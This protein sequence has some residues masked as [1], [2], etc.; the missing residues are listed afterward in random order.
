METLTLTRPD[1]WHLHLRDG[2]ILKAVLPDTAR[3]FARAIV[4]PNL[5]PPVTT[6][7]QAAAYRERILAAVPTGMAF[8]PLMTLYL[9]DNTPPAEIDA[10]R[11]CGFVHGVKLYPAGATTNSDA[12]VTDLLKCA[13]TL[14]R[15]EALGL[16]LLIHGEVTDPAVDVFDREAVFI[17]TVLSPLLK[18]FPALKVVL[19]HITTREGV[20]FVAT[21]GR[22][23][24]ATITAHHLL[25]NRNAIFVGGIRPH[26]YCLPIL[27]RETHRQALVAAAVSGNPK[28]FLGTDSAPHARSTK[29]AACGCAGCYTAHAG[30]ELYAEAFEAAGALDRLE[31]FASFHG[32]DFYGLPRNAERITLARWSWPVPASQ[33]MLAEDPLVPLRAGEAVAWRLDLTE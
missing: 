32:P 10:A 27:K 8:E 20:Q 23:V 25:L 7:A 12:G 30:I 11:D 9:T 5:K 14:A 22:N 18:D 15:M 26:H 17:D 33:T 31:A 1:D 3:R 2:A 24:A 13:A 29:E 16:P 19:E 4:M 21:A 28:F 6:V